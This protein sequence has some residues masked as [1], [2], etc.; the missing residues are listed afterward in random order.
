MMHTP[1]GKCQC[2]KYAIVSRYH[3]FSARYTKWGEAYAAK[4]EKKKKSKTKGREMPDPNKVDHL[5][6]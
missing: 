4:E 3:F 6:F 2:L 1:T 5:Y